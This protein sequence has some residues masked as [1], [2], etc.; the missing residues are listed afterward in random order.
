MA[1]LMNRHVEILI[2]R[3]R[4]IISHLSNQ[5]SAF[6]THAGLFLQLFP[7][8]PDPLHCRDRR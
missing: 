5:A 1:P 4:N 8:V 3:I 2:N 7:K 6:L